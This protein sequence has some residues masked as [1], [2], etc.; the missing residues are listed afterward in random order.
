MSVKSC[1]TFLKFLLFLFIY[2]IF[3]SALYIINHF[4]LIFGKSLF[5]LFYKKKI[6]QA[7]ECA[8][9]FKISKKMQVI[10]LC[11]DAVQQRTSTFRYQK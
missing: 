3:C 9:R 7:V 4:G 6:N 1:S 10:S 11:W 5:Q 8:L 2:S